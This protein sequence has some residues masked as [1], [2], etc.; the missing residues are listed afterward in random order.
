MRRSYVSAYSVSSCICHIPCVLHDQDIEDEYFAEVI[1][2][3]LEVTRVSL[4]GR[5][6]MS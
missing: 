3:Y 2:R 5:P 4:V 1:R 6:T